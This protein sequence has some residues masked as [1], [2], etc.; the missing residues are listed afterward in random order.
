MK[1]P[2]TRLAV[3]S[4]FNHCIY[5]LVISHYHGLDGIVLDL[6]VQVP[7]HGL[8]KNKIYGSVKNCIL[9]TEND[10][11]INMQLTSINEMN[12]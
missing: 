11:F 3:C 4:R 2:S 8:S 1:E 7:S 12:R 9:Q 5:N 6:I 10:R